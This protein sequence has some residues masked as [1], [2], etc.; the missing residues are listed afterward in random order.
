MWSSARDLLFLTPFWST[1]PEGPS[2]QV[3]CC[4]VALAT[5]CYLYMIGVCMCL[6]VCLCVRLC[7]SVNQLELNLLLRQILPGYLLP[8][9]DTFTVPSLGTGMC[10][11]THLGAFNGPYKN[12]ATNF[13]YVY[14]SLGF[15]LCLFSLI[16]C[17]YTYTHVHV[18]SPSISLTC[19]NTVYLIP[20]PLFYVCMH[21]RHPV[22]FPLHHPLPLSHLVVFRASA[23]WQDDVPSF[24][25]IFQEVPCADR[26]LWRAQQPDG[27]W[28]I[29]C[30]GCVCTC[31]HV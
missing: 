27:V 29:E 22:C 2:K 21:S 31:V 1:T 12:P 5:T 25:C 30:C 10:T 4:S 17:I 18:S 15:C 8:T 23:L 26:G 13:M 19:S 20:I 3:L 16:F 6:Y 28:V 24:V 11:C 9:V 14:L 7:D